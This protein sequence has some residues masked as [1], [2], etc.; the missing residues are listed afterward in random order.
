MKLEHHATVFVHRC[1]VPYD[2]LRYVLTGIHLPFLSK[3]FSTSCESLGLEKLTTTRNLLHTHNMVELWKGT[4]FSSW[5]HYVPDSETD[6][7]R[8]AK[9]VTRVA[10]R[11]CDTTTRTLFCSDI[12]QDKQPCKRPGWRHGPTTHYPWAL[13][14]NHADKYCSLSPTVR[15]ST[16]LWMGL[17]EEYTAST[18]VHRELQISQMLW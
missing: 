7:N 6:W 9:P 3:L 18:V 12:R 11:L 10:N 1:V 5:H 16:T 13:T 14:E 17:W 15:G 4:L 8:W 2:I